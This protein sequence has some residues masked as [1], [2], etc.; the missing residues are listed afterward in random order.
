LG[1]RLIRSAP[2]EEIPDPQAN[3]GQKKL[4]VLV[5]LHR[6]EQEI[7]RLPLLLLRLGLAEGKMSG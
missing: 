2:C 4:A 6:V 3:I 7:L 1:L 5:A